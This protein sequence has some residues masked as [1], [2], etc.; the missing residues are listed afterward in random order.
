MFHGFYSVSQITSKK[1]KDKIHEII[2]INF[3]YLP[4]V[5]HKLINRIII[6]SFLYYSTLYHIN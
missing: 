1:D 2:L 6:D 3:Y 4:N 5:Y